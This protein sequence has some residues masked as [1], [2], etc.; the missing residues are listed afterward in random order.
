MTYRGDLE[1][2]FDSNYYY[3]PEFTAVEGRI[4]EGVYEARKIQSFAK[5]ICGPFGSSIQ[6]K[7]YQETGILLIRIRNIHHSRDIDE[8]TYISPDLATKLYAY[9]VRRGDV[10]VSQ[11]GT[12]GLS[13]VVSEFF[14]GGIISANLIAIKDLEGMLPEYLEIC[15][16]SQIG[17]TQLARKT[18]GQVQPKI[19]TGDIKTLRIPFPPSDI[20]NHIVEI[21]QSAY[22]QKKQ[23]DQQVDALLDS[24]DGYVLAELGIEMPAVEEKKCFVVYANE[25]AGRRID[26]YYHSP[27][28]K[29]LYSVINNH[30]QVFSLRNLVSELD[31]GLMPTQDYADS[32]D[33]GV[34]MIRVTNLL[35]DGSIDMSEV[36]Y[37]PFDTPRLDLKRV[38]TDDILMVQCGNTTGKTAL[39]PKSFENYTFGS[40]LFVIRGKR[41]IINQHY[42]FAILSN[43]LIQE[44]IRHTWNIVTVRPNT[45]KPNVENLLIPVPSSEIQ[46]RIAEEVMTRKSEAAKLKQEADAIVEAAKREAERVMLEGASG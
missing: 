12:L 43:R 40:F 10:I 7:D 33:T 24:I 8:V 27:Y 45:S 41:E 38:K 32:G 16:N 20:Q 35:Q 2:R 31:Y 15:I 29:K 36:K 30:E 34:P 39:V 26:S 19:I 42:L 46:D 21:M 28:F 3:H 11:R 22:A 44:Q 4:T 23:K 17:R 25:T 1:S 6:V 9:Q 37:I 5:V 18:S 14:D 13:A